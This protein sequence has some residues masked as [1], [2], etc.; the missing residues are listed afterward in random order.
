MAKLR[1]AIALTL[2]SLAAGCKI[3]ITVP[4]EG[5]VA[6]ESGAI[7]CGPAETC[8]VE[9]TDVF[10]DETFIAQPQ[11]GFEF[12]GWRKRDRGFCGD[13]STPCRLATTGFPGNDD[14][15]SL[16]RS[17]QTF[18][19]EPVFEE[20]LQL[21]NRPFADCVNPVL[22]Q[23]GTQ[24]ET[25]SRSSGAPGGDSETTMRYRVEG[26]VSLGSR[27]V[28]MGETEMVMNG[29]AGERRINRDYFQ[30]G[31]D[32]LRKRTFRLE[33]RVDS[34]TDG[35]TTTVD[36]DPFRLQ[37]A[38]LVRN[39]DFIQRYRQTIDTTTDGAPQFT[40]QVKLTR[41]YLGSERIDVPAGEFEAC[42]TEVTEEIVGQ[43]T[44]IT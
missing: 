40:Q 2:A 16:L 33:A 32:P 20:V 43:P 35:S 37:R 3:E 42:R 21:G 5:R 11:D 24:Y 4:P 12:T 14:L 30:I 26:G 10:F 44:R 18:F 17:D 39:E 36:F 28:R 25:V 6:T 41:R 19:L 8:V 29:A 9:V 1:A 31:R 27:T 7:A 23:P 22:F 38:D 13:R 34:A 15:M